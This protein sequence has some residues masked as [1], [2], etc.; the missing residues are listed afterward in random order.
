MKTDGRF[1]DI[2][3][4]PRNAPLSPISQAE[5]SSASPDTNSFASTSIT[6]LVPTTRT[7]VGDQ[8]ALLFEYE[9]ALGAII[10]DGQWGQMQ[11]YTK[12]TPMTNWEIGIEA[13]EHELA[14]LDFSELTGIRME[15]DCEVIWKG[16]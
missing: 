15:F 14:Q 11:D 8:R 16:L 10:R 1:F 13:S 9:P 3:S 2:T 12:H 4:E 7:F 6:D 5:L